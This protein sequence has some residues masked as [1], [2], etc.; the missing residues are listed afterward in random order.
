MQKEREVDY[1]HRLPSETE[2]SDLRF[3]EY[4]KVRKTKELGG[5]NLVTRIKEWRRQ[6]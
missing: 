4:K 6:V 5:E 1:F 2:I 3:E